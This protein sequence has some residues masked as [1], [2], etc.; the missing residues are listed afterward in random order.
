[1]FFDI[2]AFRLIRV[3]LLRKRE[4]GGIKEGKEGVDGKK[5]ENA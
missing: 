2:R 5:E 3:D 4:N 1:M